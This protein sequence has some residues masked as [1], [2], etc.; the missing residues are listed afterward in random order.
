[1][2]QVWIHTPSGISQAFGPPVEDLAAARIVVKTLDW[3]LNTG[4]T[5]L[6][7]AF[8]FYSESTEIIATDLTTDE[9]YNYMDQDPSGASDGF[10]S[11]A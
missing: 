11:D 10:W 1:M 3:M 4:G 8:K 2:F 7:L 5:S 6:P 9:T